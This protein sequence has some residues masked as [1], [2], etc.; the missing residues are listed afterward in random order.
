M[1]NTFKRVVAS[2]MAVSS[3]T[4]SVVGMGANA[5]IN[6]DGYGYIK[7]SAGTTIGTSAL[8]VTS[9][10]VWVQSQSSIGNVYA[11]TAKIDEHSGSIGSNSLTRYD[12]DEVSFSTYAQGVSYVHSIHEIT[13]YSGS[14][15][16]GELTVYR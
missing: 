12:T 7:T 11:I 14:F 15:G 6:T 2:I 16:Y 8:S 4:V 3:L 1:K 10:S 5:S 9:S 13:P